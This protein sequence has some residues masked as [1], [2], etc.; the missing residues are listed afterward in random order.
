LSQ[1]VGLLEQNADIVVFDSPPVLGLADTTILTSRTGGAIL[2][3]DASSTHR[4]A[5]TQ[6]KTELER[7]GGTV[8]GAV[9]NSFDP[10]GSAYYYRRYGYYSTAEVAPEEKV[11]NGSK[12]GG[13]V[14][15]KTRSRF[16]LKR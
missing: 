6:A 11:Q 9:L 5:T 13:E 14:K 15:Q 7:I 12:N 10:S 3:V 16:R 4:S 2:V 1:L 8:L